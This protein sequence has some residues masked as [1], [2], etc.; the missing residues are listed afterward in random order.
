MIRYGVAYFRPPLL[1][2]YIIYFVLIVDDIS[3]FDYEFVK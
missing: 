2:L 3:K 1:L